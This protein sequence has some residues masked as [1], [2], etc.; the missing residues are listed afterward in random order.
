M[1]SLVPQ[2]GPINATY[3]SVA[4]AQ[5][6]G[7]PDGTLEDIFGYGFVPDPAEPGQ[8]YVFLDGGNPGGADCEYFCTY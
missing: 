3:I 8:L 4:N 6:L 5:R 1:I 2:D 7:G